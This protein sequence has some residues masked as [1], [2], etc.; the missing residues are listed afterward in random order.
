M[1][2]DLAIILNNGSVNSAVA[3]ALAVQKFRPILLHAEVNA[4]PGSR[5]RGAYDLQV[6]H[7]KPYR[8]HALPMP[9][10]AAV[11]PPDRSAVAM[12]AAAD[13]RVATLVTPQVLELLPMLAAA[14]R[15]AIHYH[16]GAIYLGLRVGPQGDALARATE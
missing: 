6:Q 2:K 3:T 16:A 14:A 11:Q 1:A 5:A 4:Q 12:S 15:Y 9:F 10:L 7:F 13:P 8:E